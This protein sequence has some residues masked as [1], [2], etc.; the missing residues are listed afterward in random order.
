MKEGFHHQGSKTP[1]G[2]DSGFRI[3]KG[4]RNEQEE[5]EGAE[6]VQQFRTG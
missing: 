3:Q 5:T 1:R 2:K 4:F 6:R